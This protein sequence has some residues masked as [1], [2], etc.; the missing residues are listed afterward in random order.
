[1]H[2]SVQESAKTSYLLTRFPNSRPQVQLAVYTAFPSDSKFAVRIVRL[3][4]PEEQVKKNQA[5]MIIQESRFL[6][7]RFVGVLIVMFPR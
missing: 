7:A 2:L 3:L 5:T 4:H 6:I 1:M